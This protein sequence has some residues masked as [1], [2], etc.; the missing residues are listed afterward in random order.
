MMDDAVSS[1]N[2]TVRL[3]V[4]KSTR[5]CPTEYATP[6]CYFLLLRIAA[7]CPGRALRDRVRNFV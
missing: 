2:E 5:V 4:A 7:C 1:A 6:S 3:P